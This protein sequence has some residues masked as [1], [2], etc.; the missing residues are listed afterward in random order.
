MFLPGAVQ[1][2]DPQW[3]ELQRRGYE[4]LAKLERLS[5][6]ESFEELNLLQQA[7]A[8]FKEAQR[9]TPEDEPGPAIDMLK[10]HVGAC[11]RM[12]ELLD[13]MGEQAAV[14]AALQ[15]AADVYGQLDTS[16]ARAERDECA[17][18]IVR[19]TSLL[20]QR[21]NEQLYLLVTHFEQRLLRME[22][23][24]APDSEKAGICMKLAA[25]FLRS[26]HPAEA[27]IYLRRAID[28]LGTAT[29]PADVCLEAAAHYRLGVVLAEAMGQPGQAIAHLQQ[30][31]RLYGTLGRLAGEVEEDCKAAA[32]LLSAL[33][34]R[35]P[36][37]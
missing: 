5:V 35:Q 37:S 12:V 27:A 15:E 30:A 23:E 28:Q 7:C 9:I 20:R 4:Y 14:I 29:V 10:H 8:C 22:V 34:R 18:E 32:R 33:N 6:Q 11:R 21:P 2:V 17:R 1:P 19:R 24:C 16:E 31:I 3:V 13:A 25:V 36:P 26:A